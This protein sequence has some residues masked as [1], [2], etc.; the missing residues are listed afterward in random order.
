MFPNREL[1]G[2]LIRAQCLTVQPLSCCPSPYPSALAPSLAARES[3][4]LLTLR[5][6]LRRFIL[7]LLFS[8]LICTLPGVPHIAAAVLRT[9]CRALG[10]QYVRHE[11]RLVPSAGEAEVPAPLP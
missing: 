10:D 4:D 5:L 9:Q 11:L 6:L 3:R 2:A 7:L 8:I 1:K